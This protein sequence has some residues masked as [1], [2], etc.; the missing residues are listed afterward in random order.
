MP[1]G[2]IFARLL[3]DGRSTKVAKKIVVRWRLTFL[4]QGQVRFPMH[5]YEPY[6]FEWENCWEFQTT[7]L[8][9]PL[10][11]FCSNSIWSHLRVGKQKIAKIVVVRWPRWP[12]C[13]YMVKT[14]KNLLL[15]NWE[16]LGAESLHKSSGTRDLPK[17]LKE[18]SYFDIWPFYGRVKFASLWICM[19]PIHLNRK[20]V[21]NFKL[22]LLWSLWAKFAQISY[23]AFL[24]RGEWKIA[25]MVVVHWPRWPPCPY[26]VKPFKNLLLQNY[27]GVESVHK[28]SGTGDL[29][30]LLKDC[31]TLTFDLF[32]ARSS[33]LPYAFVWA[34]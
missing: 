32:T 28:S 8:L 21:E 23:W 15:Q 13:P 2:W 18:L 12:P 10:S 7:S 26:M 25:K 31:R 1:C 29:P 5:L 33:L 17:L 11:Q 27:L 6:T 22:L 4:R 30:K 34:P 16:C 9:K 20:I 24:S 3:G 14:F 19:S